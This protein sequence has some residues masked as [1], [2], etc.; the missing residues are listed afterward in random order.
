MIGYY[1]VVYRVDGDKAAHDAWWQSVRPLFMSDSE[2]VAI[3]AISKADEVRRLD[4][5]AAALGH[6]G[7]VPCDTIDSV[8]TLLACAELPP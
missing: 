8:R 6:D 2:P 4:L 3:I 1:T 5:I 7:P